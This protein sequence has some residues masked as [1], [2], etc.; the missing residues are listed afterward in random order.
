[1]KGLAVVDQLGERIGQLDLAA[2]AGLAAG[3]VTKDLGLDDVAADDRQGR[4]R[5]RRLGFFD[6]SPRPHQPA[7]IGDD[8]E[9]P[10][11]LGV[12]RAALR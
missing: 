3:E 4:R 9:H 11:A 1:M 6:H 7:V 12:R 8:I 5:R 2:A 10:V